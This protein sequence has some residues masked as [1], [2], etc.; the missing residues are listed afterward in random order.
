MQIRLAQRGWNGFRPAATAEEVQ[1]G[2]DLLWVEIDGHRFED[3]VAAT[4]RADR[5]IA[6]PTIEL[7]LA[8]AV[9]I[10]Y[11]DT[12]GEELG[13]LGHATPG[14]TFEYGTRRPVE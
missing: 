4:V 10:V 9:E 6:V 2:V 7:Q 5:G 1:Q 3:I 13:P 11:L 14:E 8:G 12:N